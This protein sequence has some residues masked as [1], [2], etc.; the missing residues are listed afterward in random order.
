MTLIG[1]SPNLLAS[2]VRQ[3]LTGQPFHMFDF[4][5]V[6]AG[7]ALVGVIFLSVGWRLLP[8][9]R[10]GA[11]RSGMNFT[12]DDHTSELRVTEK[13]P[14]VGAHWSARLEKLGG[15]DDRDRRADPRW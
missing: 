5:P 12:L 4:T 1:T 15:G 10:G 11:P 3:E 2:A 13:S 8:H 7:I 14:F 6:G 9:R